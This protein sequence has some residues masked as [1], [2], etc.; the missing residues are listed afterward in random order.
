MVN[1]LSITL[2]KFS[3]V[4]IVL[5]T[6]QFSVYCVVCKNWDSWTKQWYIIVKEWNL[7]V[8]SFWPEYPFGCK[9]LTFW[10]LVSIISVPLTSGHHNLRIQSGIESMLI[11]YY[12]QETE[13]KEN[14]HISNA[15]VDFLF[16]YEITVC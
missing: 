11:L 3:N 13:Q 1:C 9:M 15:S 12:V 2:N 14:N 10:V 8:V 4:S 7:G 16:Q 5:R 6:K